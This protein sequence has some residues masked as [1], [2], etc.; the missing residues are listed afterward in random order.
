M[1]YPA[2]TCNTMQY[3]AIQCNTM[4]YHAI[5]CNTMQYH[6]LL[7]TADGAYHCPV[8]SIRPFFLFTRNHSNWLIQ[9]RVNKFQPITLC[10]LL[11]PRQNYGDDHLWER[12]QLHRSL[13]CSWSRILPNWRLLCCRVRKSENFPDSKIFVAKTFWIKRVNCVNYWIG[14]KCA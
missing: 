8:G 13:F 3:Y 9:Q 6:A 7:I 10:N 5:P 1:Q 4:Q 11:P 2:I 12:H 14:D